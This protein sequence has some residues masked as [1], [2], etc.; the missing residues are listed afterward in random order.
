MYSPQRVKHC[1]AVGPAAQNWFILDR[2]QVGPLLEGCEEAGDGDHEPG[3]FEAA[4]GPQVPAESHPVPVFVLLDEFLVG[5]H[6]RA[7]IEK[8]S[9]TQ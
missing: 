5:R 4:G 2:W 6:H 8:E 7:W 3:G 9:N 1:L